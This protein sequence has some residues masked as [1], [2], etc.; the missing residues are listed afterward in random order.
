MG[1]SEDS[2]PQP[3]GGNDMP[4]FA[5]PG[6]MMRLPA[7]ALH[8]CSPHPLQVRALMAEKRNG[9]NAITLFMSPMSTKWIS[10]QFEPCQPKLAKASASSTTPN[11]TSRS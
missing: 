4:R 2:F 5:G 7:A 8:R 11:A 3:L 1:N 9:K 10:V 6:T